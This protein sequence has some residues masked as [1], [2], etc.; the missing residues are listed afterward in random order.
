MLF[1][2]QKYSVKNTFVDYYEDDAEDDLRPGLQRSSSDGILSSSSSHRSFSKNNKDRDSSSDKESCNRKNNHIQEDDHKVWQT[3]SSSSH[4]VPDSPDSI[5]RNPN[6]DRDRQH[7]FDLKESKAMYDRVF[8]LTKD[9]TDIREVVE[10]HF[11]D[12]DMSKFCPRDPEADDPKP[13][14]L[15]SV[16]HLYGD[17]KPCIFFPRDRCHR[18]MLCL[19]CHFPHKIEK[20]PQKVTRPSKSRKVKMQLRKGRKQMESPETDG[21]RQESYSSRQTISL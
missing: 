3:S 20:P 11:L 21:R 12:V 2:R 10:K 8:E 7:G 9:G 1:S 19:Y 16:M 14:S 15:G 6:S 18:K 5:V 13:L 4:T 17:C